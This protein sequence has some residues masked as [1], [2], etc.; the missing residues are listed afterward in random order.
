MGCEK[1][2]KLLFP[3]TTYTH[4]KIKKQNNRGKKARFD[5][6]KLT[7]KCADKAAVE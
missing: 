7:E 1:G 5:P 2:K 4:K 6:C 3:G